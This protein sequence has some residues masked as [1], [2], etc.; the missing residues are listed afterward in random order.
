MLTSYT[1]SGLPLA[2]GE[3]HFTF[4]IIDSYWH[5]IC[6]N[7]PVRHAWMCHELRKILDCLGI[8]SRA[9]PIAAASRAD[10][11]GLEVS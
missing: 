6:H 10:D 2:G 1:R 3:N 9:P 11:G 4:Y 7:A 8:P 5:G